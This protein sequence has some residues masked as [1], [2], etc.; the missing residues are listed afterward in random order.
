MSYKKAKQF[1]YPQPDGRNTLNIRHLFRAA[2][3]LLC[4]PF[5]SCHPSN[6]YVCVCKNGTEVDSVSWN[7]PLDGSSKAAVLR[8]CDSAQLKLPSDTCHVGSY[9]RPVV[10]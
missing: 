1:Y 10:F 7:Q 8:F 3:V 6:E 9:P 2:I 4:L 5:S